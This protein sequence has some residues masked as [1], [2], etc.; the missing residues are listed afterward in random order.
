MKDS[1]LEKNKLEF[2]GLYIQ[3]STRVKATA[4]DS[5]K[6]YIWEWKEEGFKAL[7]VP[8]NPTT[9]ELISVG[10]RSIGLI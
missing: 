7:Q 1:I 5:I 10:C 6:I 2:Q 8:A 4:F 3:A 9:I